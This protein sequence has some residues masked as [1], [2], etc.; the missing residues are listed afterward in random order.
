M[1]TI[2]HTATPTKA[3]TPWIQNRDGAAQEVAPMR[4]AMMARIAQA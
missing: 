2:P 4:S 1:V 3:I